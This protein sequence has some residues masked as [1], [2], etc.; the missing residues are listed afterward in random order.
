[1]NP[2]RGLSFRTSASEGAILTMPEGAI[3]QDVEN[4]PIFRAYAASNVHRW[5]KYINGIRGR[6]AK[7]GDVRLVVGCDKAS[8]WGMAALFNTNQNCQLKF[9]PLDRQTLDSP[10]RYTWEYAGIADVRVGPDPEEVDE[11]TIDDSTT[12]VKYLNQCIF[13]RTLNVTLNDD[14]WEKLNI[15]CT[16]DFTTGHGDPLSD[17]TQL[18]TSTSG[19]FGIQRSA[20][21]SSALEFTS[22][23]D[24]ANSL[25]FSAHP[26]T[27]VSR[28]FER[29]AVSCYSTLFPVLSSL[30]Y[31]Q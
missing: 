6:E 26:T 8:S 29:R 31:P 9:K 24:N 28:V 20:G 1:V 13:V 14:D 27:T 21:E 25:I 10:S 11:L 16:P 19:N 22:H 3:S 23:D 15:G 12:G 4:I 30:P 17:N 18:M 2:Q 7:N 5:Y